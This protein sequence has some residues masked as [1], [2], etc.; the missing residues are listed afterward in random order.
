MTMISMKDFEDE[1][2]HV[3]WKAYREAEE[4]A[5]EICFKCGTYIHSLTSEYT[6]CGECKRLDKKE[7]VYHTRFIRCP[8]CEHL[9]TP[10]EERWPGVARDLY[11]DGEHEVCCQECEHQFEIS[12]QVT[13]EFQSPKLEKLNNGEL[14]D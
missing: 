6:Q 2:G 11:E 5:G 9:F 7:E 14:S 12:T 4:K 1:K 10:D 3:D 8:K 13:Y